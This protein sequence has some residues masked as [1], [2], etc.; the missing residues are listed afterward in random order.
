MENSQAALRMLAFLLF[1]KGSSTLVV[2]P[3]TD[4]VISEVGDT[5]TLGIKPPGAL[6]AISWVFSPTG[7]TVVSLNGSTPVIAPIYVNR[8]TLNTS[9]GSMELRSVNHK[10][11]D[12]YVFDGITIVS[13]IRESFKGNITLKVYDPVISKV[14]GNVTLEIQPPGALT[15]MTWTFSPAGITVVSW[16]GSAPVIGTGYVNRVTLN[17]TTGSLGLSSV[18][19]SD[20]GV[21]LFRGNTA[22]SGNP[23]NFNGSVTLEVYNGPESLTLFISPQKLIYSAGSDLALSCSAQSSPPAHYQ[24]F[25][26]GAPLNKLGSQLNIVSSRLWLKDGQPLVPSDRI[27]LSVDSSVVSFNKVLQSDNGEYQCKAYGPVNEV[28]S[29]LYRLEV[30]YGPEQ[31]SLTGPDKAALNSSVTFTC[32]AQSVPACIYI[33]YV[34]GIQ[35]AQGY[36]YQ[37]DAVSNVDTGSYMCMAWNSVTRRT[38]IA[39]KKLSVTGK[40]GPI[41]SAGEIAGIVIG[42]LA[43]VTGI[44]LGVYFSVKLCTKNPDDPKLGPAERSLDAVTWPNASETYENIA[45]VQTASKAKVLDHA[46][47]DLQSPDHSTYSTLNE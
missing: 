17:T 38:S 43:G 28:T 25:F 46:Y 31:A 18:N 19:G 20:S 34:N 2:K 39:E 14:G 36:Q 29:A 7:I 3:V 8:V 22:V 37:I 12:V 44:A 47:T 10:D 35:T 1:L 24:W 9:T 45:T 23:E 11:A 41:L 26:N 42:T 40:E 30:N 21:Y 32:S 6:A 4:P 27:T 13:G 5:V 33:W 15:A 16:S